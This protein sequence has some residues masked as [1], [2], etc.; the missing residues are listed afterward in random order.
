MQDKY[1][2]ITGCIITRGCVPIMLKAFENGTRFS[3][4]MPVWTSGEGTG[5]HFSARICFDFEEKNVHVK[6]TNDERRRL[7]PFLREI[8]L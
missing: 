6:V 5:L 2:Q 1:A 3:T 4:R 7:L 8:K